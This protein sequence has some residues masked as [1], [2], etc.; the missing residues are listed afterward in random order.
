MLMIL[1]LLFISS[2]AFAEEPSP[3]P[4]HREVDVMGLMKKKPQQLK[5]E[6]NL[7]A[8]V[9]CTDSAGHI[10]N[11][12]DFGFD[13]CVQKSLQEKNKDG[14][15]SKSATSLQYKIGK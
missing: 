8:S 15:D 12:D 10:L 7:A 14:R 1:S 11:K 13:A 2:I 5:S 9:T 6:S 4:S 3:Q